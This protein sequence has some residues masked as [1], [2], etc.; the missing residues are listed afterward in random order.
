M[1]KL[2]NLTVVLYERTDVCI[3]RQY[4]EIVYGDEAEIE[5]ELYPYVLFVIL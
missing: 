4:E 2:Q 1:W 5:T 3:N